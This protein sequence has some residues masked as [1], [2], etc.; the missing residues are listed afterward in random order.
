MPKLEIEVTEVPIPDESLTKIMLALNCLITAP[1]AYDEDHAEKWHILR[2]AGMVNE[3][4]LLVPPYLL[5]I[6][7]GK[8]AD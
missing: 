4:R 1:N 5:V 3:G 7:L 6:Q 8:Y 2:E